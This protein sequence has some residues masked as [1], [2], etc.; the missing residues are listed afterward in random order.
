[1]FMSFG[2]APVD[3]W[4]QPEVIGIDYKSAHRKENN[5]DAQACDLCACIGGRSH[6]RSS[7]SCRTQ[8]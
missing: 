3:S 5:S 4:S 7:R 6:L 8:P 1:M 2:D